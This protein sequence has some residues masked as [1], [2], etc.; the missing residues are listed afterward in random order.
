MADGVSRVADDELRDIAGLMEKEEIP[1]Y[2]INSAAVGLSLSDITIVGMID[3]KPTCRINLSFTM[4]KTIA[5]T[6]TEVV[7][8]V[9]SLMK[10]RIFTIDD[11]SEATASSEMD[12]S[13]EGD[14]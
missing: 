7:G 4:A 3:G 1:M 12:E 8:N 10:Q 5:Q 13:E 14:G 2:Y 9:E 6:L 11:M